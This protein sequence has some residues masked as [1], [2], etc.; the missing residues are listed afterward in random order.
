MQ[1]KLIWS[2]TIAVLI[3]SSSPLAQS[4]MKKTIIKAA[5]EEEEEDEEKNNYD[6]AEMRARRSRTKLR[7]I[8]RA[9]ETEE[10]RQP[11]IYSPHQSSST[12]YVQPP[13]PFYYTHIVYKPRAHTVGQPL[14]VL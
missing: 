6:F 13:I 11:A 2:C 10:V 12:V 3:L 9:Q 8:T 7:E 14:D 4:G 5:V 1:E